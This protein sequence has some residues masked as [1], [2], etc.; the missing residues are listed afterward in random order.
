MEGWRS[1]WT[2]LPAVA[3][4]LSAVATG[5][6]P[7]FLPRQALRVY[8][9]D[10][11]HPSEVLLCYECNRALVRL[12]DEEPETLLFEGSAAL[13]RSEAVFEASDIPA[14]TPEREQAEHRLLHACQIRPA[15]VPP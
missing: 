15:I 10:S 5:L 7:C 3:D 8:T 12:G 14:S 11:D 2:L 4:D 9:P 1:W 6:I 13:D